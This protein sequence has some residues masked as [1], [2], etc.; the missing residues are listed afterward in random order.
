VSEESSFSIFALLKTAGVRRLDFRIRDSGLVLFGLPVQHGVDSDGRPALLVPLGRDEIDITDVESRAIS[1]R[2]FVL[3]VPEGERYLVVRCENLSLERQFSL[4]ADDVLRALNTNPAEPGLQ[5]VL[6]LGRWRTLLEPALTQLLSREEQIGLIAE[7]HVLE[8]FLATT[9][10]QSVAV[11]TGPDRA[12]HDFAR[13]QTLVEVKGTLSREVLAVQIHGDRQLECPDG[14][15]LYL[16]V[17]QF[18]LSPAGDTVSDIVARILARLEDP[19]PFL[20]KLA[21]AG[22]RLDDGPSYEDFRLSTLRSKVMVVDADFPRISRSSLKDERILDSV[23][24]L[25]YRLDVGPLPA[26]VEDESALSY[27][28]GKL[29]AL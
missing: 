3:G 15:S 16:H 26:S 29:V 28:S 20:T 5:C 22:F 8:E 1:M 10:S 25:R 19:K 13:G 18:E 24:E 12:R 6:T 27:T 21:L 14:S 9:S 23:T 17:E 11:W 4:F 7:L 2:T